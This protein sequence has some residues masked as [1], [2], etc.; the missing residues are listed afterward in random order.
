MCGNCNNRQ[1]A[2]CN[3]CPSDTRVFTS[4]RDKLEIPAYTQSQDV[5]RETIMQ[6]SG[7]AEEADKR[8]SK[9]WWLSLLLPFGF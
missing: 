2:I 1:P 9:L 7:E 5:L 6:G 4:Y 8:N 3:A